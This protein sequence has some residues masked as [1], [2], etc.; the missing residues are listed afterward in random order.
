MNVKYVD[1]K[2]LKP[3]KPEEWWASMNKGGK[4]FQDKVE[5]FFKVE[6]ENMN[7]S[8]RNFQDRVE[9]FVQ[10][11]SLGIKLMDVSKTDGLR[12]SS[13]D[14]LHRFNLLGVSYKKLT[15]KY[16]PGPMLGEGGFGKVLPIPSRSAA[17]CIAILAVVSREA[18]DVCQR[19]QPFGACKS[20]SSSYGSACRCTR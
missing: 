13:L 7:R 3:M 2:M 15:K 12:R 6:W 10:D 5:N 11:V 8:G 19:W 14:R 18:L 17:A 9:K 16:V 1:R 4:E 20:L